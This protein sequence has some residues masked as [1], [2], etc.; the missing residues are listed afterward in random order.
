MPRILAGLAVALV[1]SL[2]AGNAHARDMVEY[3]RYLGVRLQMWEESYDV[4][5]KIISGGSAEEKARARRNKAEVMKAEADYIFSQDQDESGRTA[6]YGKALAEFGDP[7]DAAGVVAKGVMQL[8]LAMGLRRTDPTTARQYCDDA[9]KMLN[10]KR[11]YLDEKVRYENQSEWEKV[12]PDYSRMFFHFCRGYY[13]K[14]MCFEAGSPDRE[15]NF[16]LCERN[17]DEFQFS[18]DYPTEEL[19]LT[20]PLLGDIEL[21]RGHPEAA[22]SQFTGCISFLQGEAAT[23]YLGRLALEHGYLRA[24]ELLTTELDFDP[25]NLEKCVDLYA[26]A[27]GK[28]GQIS[29]LNF[30]FKR[31]QLYRI[32]ALI[33]LGDEA[34][35]RGAIDLLFKLAADRDITF[36]R[37]ALVVLSDIATRDSLDNELRFKCAGIVYSELD[38]N[39]VSVI[40]KNIQAYQSLIAA[41]R[42]VKTFETYAP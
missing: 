5:D 26:E 37:Q 21:A 33:K 31:F 7:E 22:V 42:D 24:A 23:E 4:L 14:G 12:Y 3:G 17:I 13:V 36:R 18:L 11:V 19:V 20:Y 35:V 41:C 15:A 27:F 28:Y 39:P 6:R 30:Y 10:D 2:F 40:L 29:E 38:S 8:D 9:I 25:R 1:L 32:S 34:K 16:K